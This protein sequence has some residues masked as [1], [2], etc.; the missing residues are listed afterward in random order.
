MGSGRVA[1]NRPESPRARAWSQGCVSRR[2]EGLAFATP[3]PPWG[4]GRRLWAIAGWRFPDGTR[5]FSPS[6]A[7]DVWR[8]LCAL[9]QRD[10]GAC[11]G[12]LGRRAA[13]AFSMTSI[14]GSASAASL[15]GRVKRRPARNFS[16]R[17]SDA[18]ASAIACRKS[19]LP[20]PG[21]PTL[22]G[23]DGRSPAAHRQA[24]GPVRSA[25]PDGF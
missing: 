14:D 21:L 20:D 7:L 13:A 1:W 23:G 4:A 17:L 22:H 6:G 12:V 15:G 10:S 3:T 25:R 16:T 19:L 18:W 9:R 5:P 8:S 2:I 11:P 24:I